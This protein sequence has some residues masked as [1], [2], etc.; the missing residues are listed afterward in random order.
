MRMLGVSTCPLTRGYSCY[1]LHEGCPRILYSTVALLA[2]KAAKVRIHL[3]I[4]LKIHYINA[5]HRPPPDAMRDQVSNGRPLF[6][7]VPWGIEYE[8]ILFYIMLF[9]ASLMRDALIR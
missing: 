6:T 2:A 7:A 3:R 9:R 5:E 8:N 4:P 1:S